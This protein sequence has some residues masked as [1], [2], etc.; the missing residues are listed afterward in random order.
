MDFSVGKQ[1]AY[2]AVNQFCSK[3]KFLLLV[4]GMRKQCMGTISLT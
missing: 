2:Q 4:T 1:A 3:V